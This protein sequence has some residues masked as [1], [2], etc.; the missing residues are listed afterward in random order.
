MQSVIL[1]GQISEENDASEIESDCEAKPTGSP[2]AAREAPPEYSRAI[3]M[4]GV[5]RFVLRVANVLPG[6]RGKTA[7]ARSRLHVSVVRLNRSDIAER[8]H[9]AGFSVEEAIMPDCLKPTAAML[10]RY[11]IAKSELVHFCRKPRADA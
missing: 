7:Q 2:P 5:W 11:N 10:K 8:L 3:L 6:C 4:S 9:A 1:F